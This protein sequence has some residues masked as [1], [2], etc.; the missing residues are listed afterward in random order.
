MWFNILEP[1]KSK[2]KYETTSE[3]PFELSKQSTKFWNPEILDALFSRI[4][5]VVKYDK[6]L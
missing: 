4:L 6:E 5:L 1:L 2:K 3:I